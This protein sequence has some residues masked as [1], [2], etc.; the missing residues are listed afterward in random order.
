MKPLDR[1]WHQTHPMPVRASRAQRV[2]WHVEHKLACGCREVPESL[3]PDVE[4][5][6]RRAELRRGPAAA[7]DRVPGTAGDRSDESRNETSDE[8]PEHPG[9]QDL[10]V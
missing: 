2:A 8:Q 3:K 7:A 9:R 1:A 5:G 6:V 4:A 10:D